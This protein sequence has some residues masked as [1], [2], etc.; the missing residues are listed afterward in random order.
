MNRQPNI[1]M[2]K[3][4]PYVAPLIP[5]VI[6]MTMTYMRGLRPQEARRRRFASSMKSIH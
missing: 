3:D 1:G 2:E 4:A 5:V 6:Q